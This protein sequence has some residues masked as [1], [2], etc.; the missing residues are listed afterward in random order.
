M[1][2]TQKIH[3]LRYA[4]V[5]LILTA[6]AAAGVTAATGWGDVREEPSAP[7]STA[8]TFSA[9]PTVPVPTGQVETARTQLTALRVAPMG[10]IPGYSRGQFGQRWADIDHNGCD[11]RN[12]VL[13]AAA[14]TVT[15]KPGTHDCVIATATILDPYSGTEISFVK[16]EDTVDI[17]HVVPLGRAWQQ[18]AASWTPAQREQF[19]NTPTELAAVGS[20]ANRAKG[21]RGPEEWMPTAG[22]CVYAVRWIDVK[23][24]FDLTVTEQEK[25]ALE[26]AMA[27]CGGRS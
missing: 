19:A 26:G 16:G 2:A 3:H 20:S 27:T 13:R 5:T 25:N 14:T 7:A 1:T 6:A 4:A 23:T 9:D 24:Q 8:V 10:D 15:T 17:D 12:D 18:G 21:D 11:Q 22:R